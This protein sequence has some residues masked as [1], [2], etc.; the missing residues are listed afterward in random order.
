VTIQLPPRDPAVLERYE[1][2]GVTRAVHMLRAHDA[3]DAGS[4]ESK[5]D[6][7]TARIQA[8]TRAG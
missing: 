3:V 1:Q 8:Y 7:W 6:E 2:A 5:L 4:A